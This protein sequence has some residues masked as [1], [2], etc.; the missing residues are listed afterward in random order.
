MENVSKIKEKCV[1]CKSC[2]QSCPKRCVSMIENKEGFWYPSVD[3]KSCIECKICLKRCPVENIEVHRNKP[4]KVWAWR[5]RNDNDIMRS[6]SG[7]ASDSAARTILQMGGVVYGAAYDEQLTVS[8]IEVADD[9]GREKIQSSKYVQSDLKDSYSKV[10]KYL[11]EDKI[12][13]YTGTPCQIAGLYAFLS[14]DSPNLY[15]ID[16]I[17][18]GVP[19][20]KFFRRYLEYQSKKTAGKVIY[21]NFRSKDKRGWGTQYLLK[22]KT[23][24]KTKMLSLDRYGKHFMDGDCYRECCYLCNY[25]NMSRVGD[26][27]IGDFWG[28]AKSHPNFYSPKGVSSVFINTE[29]GQNLFQMMMPLAMVEE[30]TL[31]EGMVK[32]HNLVQ[33]SC[34]P[35]ARDAFYSN[36]DESGFI[37]HIKVGVQLKARLKSVLPNK[38]IQKIKSL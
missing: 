31:D 33:P 21:F 36:I 10:K 18:H 25:A 12:V 11:S 37:E 28:I 30:A 23:K 15:T 32:Q 24:T 4:K 35:V 6:A 3:E 26:L 9:A 19:S 16:L 38:L 20:P 13:L 29:K 8:H 1:G 2:E 34:R 14:G 22:T 7:G 17:C 27:T 5:N